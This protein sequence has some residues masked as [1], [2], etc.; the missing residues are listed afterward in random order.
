MTYGVGRR[1]DVRACAR[2]WAATRQQSATGTP[3]SFTA[4]TDDPHA[5]VGTRSFASF[6]QAAHE[7][8]DS[9]VWLGVHCPWDASDGYALGDSIATWVF[10]HGMKPAGS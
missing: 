5:P 9:R 4:S 1:L 10:T 6:S 8:A 7:D 2:T 3:V